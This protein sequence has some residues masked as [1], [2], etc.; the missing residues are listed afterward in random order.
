MATNYVQ[1]GNT[2]QWTNGGSAVVS[3]AVV[4]IGAMLGIALVDIGAGET[5]SVA[6]EGVFNVPK[7]DAAVIAAGET[8]VWDSSASEFDDSAATPASGDVSGGATAIE[9]KGANTGATIAI[10]LSGQA[11]TLT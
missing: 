6:I 2:I 1:E 8:V 5:G 4:V 11:G 9:G 10:K 3:G 7:V